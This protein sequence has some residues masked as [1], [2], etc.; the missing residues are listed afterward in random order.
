[1]KKLFDKMPVDEAVCILDDMSE[2]RFK[3]GNCWRTKRIL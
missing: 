1:M 3:R 2:R